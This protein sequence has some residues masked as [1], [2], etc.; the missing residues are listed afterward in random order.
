M[1]TKLFSFHL[2]CHL[3]KPLPLRRF[4]PGSPT[5]NLERILGRL[6]MDPLGGAI[7]KKEKD[8]KAIPCDESEHDALN[9]VDLS[10][11]SPVVDFKNSFMS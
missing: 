1:E 7:F 2:V 6:A 8:K 11:F 9:L 10:L 4:E 5:T 3:K